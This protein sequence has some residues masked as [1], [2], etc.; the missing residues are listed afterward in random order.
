MNQHAS[1]GYNHLMSVAPGLARAVRPLALGTLPTPVVSNVI[2]GHE[3][4]I[5]CDQHT[6][7]VLGGNKLRKLRF[8]LRPPLSQGFQSVAT[9]GAIGSNHAVATAYAARHLG[10]EPVAYLA[11]QPATPQIAKALEWHRCLGTRI[12]YWGGPSAVRKQQVKRAQRAAALRPWLIPLGGSSKCGSLG[13]VEAAF[14]LNAQIKAEECVVPARIYLAMGTMGSA[15]GLAIGLAAA[16]L[17]KT[18]VVAV[19]VVPTRKGFSER[20]RQF[21]NSLVQYC[22]HYEPDFDAADWFSQLD[23]RTEF[24]GPGY[25]QSTPATDAAIEVA[26]AELGLELETTYSGKSMAAMRSDLQNENLPGVS[27]YWNTYS[28]NREPPAHLHRSQ[29]DL[30]PELAAFSDLSG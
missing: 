20:V 11:K 27:L 19:Q 28:G 26:A 6:D 13:F 22:R 7:P 1:E 18:R 2:D 4:L 17:S 10:L 3:V 8:L 30:P 24:V 25:A 5:K 16:G 9:L 23:I 29:L 12:V 14:E 21:G 15:V